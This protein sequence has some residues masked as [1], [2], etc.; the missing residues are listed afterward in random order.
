MTPIRRTHL[1]QVYFAADQFYAVGLVQQANLAW[2]GVGPVRQ[3][4]A[5]DVQSLAQAIEAA[6]S[7]CRPFTRA[8][9]P[10]IPPDLIRPWDGE[11]QD[12]PKQATKAWSVA[13]YEDGRAVIEPQEQL[14]PSN[15]P[16]SAGSV[17]WRRIFGAEIALEMP[18]VS[19]ALAERLM[20]AIVSTVGKE[21]PPCSPKSVE[22]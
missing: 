11:Y 16:A 3:A 20:G 18:V 15:D 8:A 17:G 9:P 4:A 21:K 1:I 7:V 13:W 14:P 10:M 12:V 19:I 6:R 2:K 5:E 22:S